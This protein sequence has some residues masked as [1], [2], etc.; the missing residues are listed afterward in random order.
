MDVLA[1]RHPRRE[2]W[3][4]FSDDELVAELFLADEGDGRSGGMASWTL[5]HESGAKESIAGSADEPPLEAAQAR[6][7]AAV[8][9]RG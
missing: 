7:E 4:F 1:R 8:A 5:R 9:G 6:V 3:Q 2:R